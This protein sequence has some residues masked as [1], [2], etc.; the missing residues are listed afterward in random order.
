LVDTHV[1]RLR[2]KVEED[3]SDPKM[4]VTVRGL[5]YKLVT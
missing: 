3:A 5:G 2:A 1:Y 4:I